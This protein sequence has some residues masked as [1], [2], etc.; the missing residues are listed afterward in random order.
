MVLMAANGFGGATSCGTWNLTC[1]IWAVVAAALA[2]PIAS[3]MLWNAYK[4]AEPGSGN[5]ALAMFALVPCVLVSVA[6]IC[7]CLFLG[8]LIH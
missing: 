7:A 1:G 5:R 4:D 2:F 3:V 8:S 6:G